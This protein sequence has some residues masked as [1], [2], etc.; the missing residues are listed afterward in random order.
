MEIWAASEII[1]EKKIWKSLN[2]KSYDYRNYFRGRDERIWTSDPLNPIQVRSQTALHPDVITG[3]HEQ[4]WTADLI[5]T[6]D[7]LYRLSHMGMF[8]STRDL[9]T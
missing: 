6:K 9:C 2:K 7:T 1:P 4:D 3:A 5:L 8:Q